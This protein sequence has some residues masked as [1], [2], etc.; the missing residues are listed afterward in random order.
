MVVVPIV[1]VILIITLIAT[2]SLSKFSGNSVISYYCEDN[3]YAL[4]GTDCVKTIVKKSAL[5][6]DINSDKTVDENDLNLLNN[7]I[8]SG[9]NDN[10][11]KLQFKV[12][13]IN[14]DGMVN[15][16]DV[17]ILEGYFTNVAST[18][19]CKCSNC[20]VNSNNSNNSNSNR[21]SS[22]GCPSGWT[23]APSGYC[24]INSPA[25]KYECDKKNGW[26]KSGSYCVKKAKEIVRGYYY[27]CPDGG[28]FDKLYLTCNKSQTAVTNPCPSN[29]WR[30]GDICIHN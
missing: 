22:N 27:V 30:Q 24:Y 10:F 16:M 17:Q 29:S 13:D 19:T 26:Q 4:E 3:S 14:L 15:E 8:K 25:I 1:L 5:L 7:H 21:G 23:K 28:T 18:T 12:A 20:N 2:G 6:A 11:S 9:N